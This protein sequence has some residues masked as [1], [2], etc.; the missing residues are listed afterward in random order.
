MPCMSQA[1]FSPDRIRAAFL[2]CYASLLFNYRKHLE[3]VPASQRKTAEGK[4]YDFK[5]SAFLR[6]ASRDTT[7]YL[8]MLSETQAFNEFIMERCLKSPNDNE[9]VLFDQI[10]LAKRNRG[11]H[12]LFGKQS[13]LQPFIIY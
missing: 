1:N 9:I 13:I 7:S 3:P 8:E 12:G 2:R 10:I 4:L 11:R 6:A 5:M